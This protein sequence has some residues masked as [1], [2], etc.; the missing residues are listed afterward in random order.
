[1]SHTCQVLMP[2]CGGTRV[3]RHE[4]GRMTL[5]EQDTKCSLNTVKNARTVH[6][7]TVPCHSIPTDVFPLVFFFVC[8]LTCIGQMRTLMFSS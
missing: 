4:K 2:V 7:L 3:G 1:M 8:F 5:I 6:L